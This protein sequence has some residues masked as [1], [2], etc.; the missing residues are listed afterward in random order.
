MYDG[1]LRGC[2]VV[3]ESD[4]A[5]SEVDR[6]PRTVRCDGETVVRI[7]S[8]IEQRPAKSSFVPGERFAPHDRSSGFDYL[9]G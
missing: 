7:H 9:A 4:V 6:K 3:D 5:A 1:Y 8:Y 2:L